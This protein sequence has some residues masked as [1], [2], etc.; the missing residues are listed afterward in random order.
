M[1]IAHLAG[2]LKLGHHNGLPPLGELGKV[3]IEQVHIH[4]LGGLKVHQPVGRPGG[5]FGVQGLEVVVHGDGVGVPRRFSSSS[6]IFR[7]VVVLP[8]PEGPESRTMGLWGEVGQNGVGGLADLLGVLGVAFL[9][10]PFTSWSMRRL[11][12]CS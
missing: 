2:K 6:S 9:K 3:G 5:G 11:I 8:D 4:A 12:S 1:I 7:A 10:N